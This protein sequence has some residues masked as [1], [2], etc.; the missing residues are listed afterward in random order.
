MRGAAEDRT[1][2]VA[3]P[4]LT[5]GDGDHI[6]QFYERDG[7]LLAAVT[8]YLAAAARAGDVA[9]VI[10]TEAHRRAFEAGLRAERIDL[11]SAE[12]S[13]A[14][15]AL[16]AAETLA[17]LMVDG[18]IDHDAFHEVIGGIVRRAVVSGRGVRAYG[19]MV[20]LLWEAGNVLG[21]IELETLWH[22]LG[23]EL[24]FSLFC[25]YP[26]ASVEGSQHAHA[27]QQVCQLHSSVVNPPPAPAGERAQRPIEAALAEFAAERDMPGRARRLLVAALEQCGH[28]ERLVAD[29]A[30]VLSELA[31]NAVLH[32]GSSFSVEVRTKDST[33][34]IAVQDSVPPTSMLRHG[35]LI[36]RATHG[37]G[38]VQALSRC[39]GVEGTPEGKVVWA[40]LSL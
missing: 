11:A 18:R 35:G 28:D 25:S 26:S 3:P 2:A 13:G 8:P 20:A 34:R 32:A 22:E 12:A 36:P 7:E 23:R 31:S 21:A 16:D 14:F 15:L 6:A 19:E 10:A 4:G 24:A 30:L 9:I 38:V 1:V 17:L 39:W 29:A 40:E 33:L 5:L 37:L 27:L